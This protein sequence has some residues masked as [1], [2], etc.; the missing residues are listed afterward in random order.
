M[1]ISQK[2]EKSENEK[3]KE[4][5]SVEVDVQYPEKLCEHH[6]DLPFLPERRKL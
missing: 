4:G 2:T 1:K 5:Y 3:S 6:S